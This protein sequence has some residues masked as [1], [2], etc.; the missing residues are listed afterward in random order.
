MTETLK[1]ISAYFET[2][3]K[4]DGDGDADKPG[5]TGSAWEGYKQNMNGGSRNGAREH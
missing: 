3:R 4:H 2:S 1:V 5:A